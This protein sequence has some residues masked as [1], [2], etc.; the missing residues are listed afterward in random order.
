M[1]NIFYP[2]NN[3]S[4]IVSLGLLSNNQNLIFIKKTF[5]PDINKLTKL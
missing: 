5:F 2:K 1:I 4:L 3:H